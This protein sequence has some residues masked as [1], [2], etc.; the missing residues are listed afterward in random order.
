MI[1]YAR[2]QV[3]AYHG[4]KLVAIA[5]PVKEFIWAISDTEAKEKCLQFMAA[6]GYVVQE[7]M[8]C[9]AA[10]QSLA[11]YLNAHAII[12]LPWSMFA[13]VVKST[14]GIDKQNMLTI[15]QER[16]AMLIKGYL[17]R[18]KSADLMPSKYSGAKKMA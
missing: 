5:E 18:A 16:R 17:S 12:D 6:T 9:Q 14:V 3:A 13:P 4:K 11:E 1:F 15:Y 10:H 7:V 2:L 8:V